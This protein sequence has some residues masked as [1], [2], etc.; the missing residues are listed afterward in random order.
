MMK[1]PVLSLLLIVCAV[2]ATSVVA[3]ADIIVGG[4]TFQ[5]NAFADEVI[6]YSAGAV[7]QSYTTDPFN[8]YNVTAEAAL[9]GSDL[10]SSTIE[11]PYGGYVTVGFTDNLI[12]NGA[13]T[14]LIIFEMFSSA[15]FGSVVVEL[16][17][18]ALA[19]SVTSLG[20]MDI[21]GVSNYVNIASVDLSDYGFAANQTTDYVRIFGTSSEYAAFGALNNSQNAPVPEPCTVLLLGSGLAGLAAFRKRFKA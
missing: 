17:G 7:F 15:E 16:G 19:A 20:Y 8:R 2:F 3:N 21:G 1:R 10:R 18:T 9:L 5:D 12:F 6:D 11:L 4:I 14:D 13:G